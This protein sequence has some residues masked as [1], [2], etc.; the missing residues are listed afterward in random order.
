MSLVRIV[1]KEDYEVIRK[2][3]GTEDGIVVL[4]PEDIAERN[5]L[6][7]LDEADVDYDCG[8]D[9]D[10]WV[11]LVCHDNHYFINEMK[12]KEEE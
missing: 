11:E 7:H 4:V 3:L 1:S 10:K 8:G 9:A 6:T 12:E 2:Y 5:Q